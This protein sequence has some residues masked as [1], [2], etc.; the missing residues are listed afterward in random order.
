MGSFPAGREAVAA[1]NTLTQSWL[2]MRPL[3][4]PQ[5][6][7]CGP[8]PAPWASLHLSF[9]P[10]KWD[11]SDCPPSGAQ[12]SA[13][14][15]QPPA[16]QKGSGGYHADGSS[17][18]R[19]LE[20]GEAGDPTSSPG[21][22]RWGPRT[23]TPYGW[24]SRGAGEGGGG[25]ARSGNVLRRW[26]KVPHGP[27]EPLNGGT[28]ASNAGVSSNMACGGWPMGP[29]SLAPSLQDSGAWLVPG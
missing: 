19:R 27:Q 6:S 3:T 2:R 11:G 22:Q 1:T 29:A 28:R 23:K 16:K 13:E 25:R 4:G 21:G 12:V 14:P 17:K 7:R 5:I 10:V 8:R 18:S 26:G 24:T 9:L 15:S 20:P